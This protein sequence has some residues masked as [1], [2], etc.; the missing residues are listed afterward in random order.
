MLHMLVYGVVG[1]KKIRS[2]VVYHAVLVHTIYASRVS[3][4]VSRVGV[5]AVIHAQRIAAVNRGCVLDVHQSVNAAALIS[6]RIAV[7][8]VNHA[9]WG[10]SV[11]MMKIAT[12]SKKVAVNAGLDKKN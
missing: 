11:G 8:R 12:M 4:N 3:K 6:V 7:V 5:I 9:V 2:L 10:Y 1:T